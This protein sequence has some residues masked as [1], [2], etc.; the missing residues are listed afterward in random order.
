MS[1]IAIQ[2]IRG[3]YS[4]EAALSLEVGAELLECSN[5]AETFETL[6]NERAGYAVVP[7]ENKIVG[8]IEGTLQ[9]LRGGRFRILEKTTL[10]VRHV[11]AGTPESSLDNIKTVTSHIEALK[12]CQQYLGTRKGC[13]QIIGDDTAR[14]IR[15]IVVNGKPTDSAVGSER[16]AEMYGAKVLARDIA[17]D[18]NNWTTF[19]LV[20]K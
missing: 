2:G 3:S 20:S 15:E 16:A 18:P 6:E 10:S 1:K 9:F 17:N 8:G 12:Q 4:E 19:Y 13:K 11:L 5:F 14:S 7:V